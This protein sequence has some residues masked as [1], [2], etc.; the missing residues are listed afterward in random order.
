MLA[1]QACEL[2]TDAGSHA[3]AEKSERPIEVRKQGR[4]EGSDERGQAGERGL[5]QAIATARKLNRTN[6]YA[7]RAVVHPVAVD[8]GRAARIREAK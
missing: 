3:V 1:Q 8:H 2:K 6:L 5:F 4:A 7:R